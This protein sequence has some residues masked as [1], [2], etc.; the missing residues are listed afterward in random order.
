MSAIGR[1][2]CPVNTLVISCTGSKRPGT[3]RAL[4]LYRA[5]QFAV[6]RKFAGLGWRVL[7]LSAEHGLI[8]G[9]DVIECYERPMTKARA[10][11]L[12]KATP[13]N[14]PSTGPVFVYGGSEYRGIVRAW[15]RRLGAS[16]PVEVVGRNR[17]NGDHYSALVDLARSI[18]Q[19]SLI[20]W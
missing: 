10:A 13:A 8:D 18:R 17:G 11:E 14:Y 12:T 9:G 19:L 7:V 1:I 20:P 15:A 16:Y 2:L 4:D 5:R 3:H 6:A